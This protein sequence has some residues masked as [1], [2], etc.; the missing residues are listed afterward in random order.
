MPF[1]ET[2]YRGRI[3]MFAVMN[4]HPLPPTEKKAARPMSPKLFDAIFK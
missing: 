4:G 3:K 2:A 1:I